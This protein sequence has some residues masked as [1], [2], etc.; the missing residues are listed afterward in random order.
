MRSRLPALSAFLVASLAP[1][2]VVAQQS[3]PNCP[4]GSWFCEESSPPAATNTPPPALPPPTVTPPPAASSVAPATAAPPANQAAPATTIIV[5][6][7]RSNAPPVVVYQQAPPAPPPVYVVRRPT[8]VVVPPPPPPPR[9]R[10]RKWGLNLRLQ[11]LI[12]D[13]QQS[14]ISGMGGVG[15]SFRARPVPFFA[16][17]FGL[18]AVGGR[19]YHGNTRSEVPF[20]IS[21]MF[22]VNPRNPV[23]FYLIGGLG[24]SSARVQ[25]DNTAAPDPSATPSAGDPYVIERYSYFGGHFGGGLEFRLSQPVSLNLDLIGFVR[26]RTDSKARDYPEFVDEFG[27]TT[28]SSGG[29]LFRAGITF[30]W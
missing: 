16:L 29:G 14:Q 12:M 7:T 10:W 24:W 11:G 15:A 1:A 9:A 8:R 20:T 6:A 3:S 19:D 23:Q 26:G 21:G 5:P 18:D 2:L 25:Y 27:R 13:D 28:N 30:Y 22:F 17:D 4:P